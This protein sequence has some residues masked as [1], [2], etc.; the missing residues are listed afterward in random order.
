[1]TRVA[2]KRAALTFANEL[3]ALQGAEPAKRLSPG[4]DH[5]TGDCPIARTATIDGSGIRWS[6]GPVAAAFKSGKERKTFRRP[7][8]AGAQAFM[9]AFDAGEF[10][11]LMEASR[12]AAA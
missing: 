8:P 1:M 10:P 4:N 6:I 11:S 9:A 2:M 3:R 12:K 5:D 7:T